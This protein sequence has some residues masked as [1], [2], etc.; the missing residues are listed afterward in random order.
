MSNIADLHATSFLLDYMY[1]SMYR[2]QLKAE[3]FFLS[4]TEP[5]KQIKRVL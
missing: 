3:M 2:F 5:K 4:K 1:K